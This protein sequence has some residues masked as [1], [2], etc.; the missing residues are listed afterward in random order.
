MNAAVANRALYMLMKDGV[1]VDVRNAAGDT[2]K[3]RVRVVDWDDAGANEFLVVSQ[4]WVTGPFHTRRPDL[5]GFV[6]GLPLVFIELKAPKE[7]IEDAYNN[8][9]TDYRDTIP[10][11]FTPNAFIILSNGTQSKIGS[12]TGGW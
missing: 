9:L 5:I 12:I 3:E 11:L 7:K 4:L 10:S 6:N 1:T 2:V 8:N